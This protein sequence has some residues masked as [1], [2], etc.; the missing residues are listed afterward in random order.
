MLVDPEM[1][2]DWAAVFDVDLAKSR[3]AGRPVMRLAKLGLLA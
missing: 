1:E 2:N 3:D